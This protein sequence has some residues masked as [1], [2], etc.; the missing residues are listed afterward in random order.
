MDKKK[1]INQQPVKM[2]SGSI[3]KRL[4]A[5]F[6]KS[7]VLPESIGSFTCNILRKATSTA[8]HVEAPHLDNI[9]TD[10]MSHSRPTAEGWYHRPDKSANTAKAQSKISQY[11]SRGQQQNQEQQQQQQ[12]QE[13][14]QQQQNQE[15]QQ[16][17]GQLEEDFVI[18]NSEC[19]SSGENYHIFTDNETDAITEL[20][21]P[22][23]S[24]TEVKQHF[25][26][27]KGKISPLLSPQKV[28]SKL[29]RIRHS[30]YD[31]SCKKRLSSYPELPEEFKKKRCGGVLSEEQLEIIYYEY[32][33][34]GDVSASKIRKRQQERNEEESI[35]FVAIQRKF[36]AWKTRNCTKDRDTSE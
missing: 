20:F 27:L 18:E 1:P 13:Q 14:Q 10:S 32:W 35:P 19:S 5:M 24:I 36:S 2:S 33:K 3:S 7:G 34:K 31:P 17:Q 4:R 22:D 23:T 30:G 15:Q 28:H 25:H 8:L 11:W 12:N 9:I 16:Q 6:V 29:K 21:V 26:Q